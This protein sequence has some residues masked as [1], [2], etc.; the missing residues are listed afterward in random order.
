MFKKID[1]VKQTV[2]KLATAAN[3]AKN[4]DDQSEEEEENKVLE[5][6]ESSSE[7]E[8]EETEEEEG[9]SV[10]SCRMFSP[11]D[12]REAILN[13]RSAWS[14]I[15][16]P[17]QEKVLKRKYFAAIYTIQMEIERKN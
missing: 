10:Y 5:E 2:A 17:V 9:N 3:K 14:E 15:N 16:L 11:V 6:D 13:L 8:E 1:S 7:S 12:D 4:Y